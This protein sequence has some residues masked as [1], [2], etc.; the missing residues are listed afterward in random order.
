MK[1]AQLSVVNLLLIGTLLAVSVGWWL[2]HQRFG[3]A[4]V[5][6]GQLQAGKGTAASENEQHL[7]RQYIPLVGTRKGAASTPITIVEFVDFQCPFCGRATTT[8]DQVFKEYLGQVR[9]YV[10]HSPL[11]FHPDASQAAEAALAAEAQGKL[12][13]MHDKLIADPRNLSR[14]NIEGYAREIGLD[15]AKFLEALDAQAYKARIKTDIDLAEQV[16]ASGTP[17]FFIN[18]RKLSG[19]QPIE[20]FKEVIDE[21][22]ARAQKVVASGTPAEKVYDVLTASVAPDSGKHL[23]R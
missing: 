15:M 22:L 9:F 19:A 7:E 1:P 12:W 11:P 3:A 18:G 16:G 14:K 5:A 23:R 8:I 20:A 6:L 13:E 10:R 21:E 2:E 4:S 17:T